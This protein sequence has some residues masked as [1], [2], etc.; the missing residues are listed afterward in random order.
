MHAVKL[1]RSWLP[2]GVLGAEA[3]VRTVKPM[4]GLV[5]KF[6]SL[7]VEEDKEPGVE[8]AKNKLNPEEVRLRAQ[9]RDQNSAY[10]GE[11]PSPGEG[12]KLCLPR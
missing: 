4:R 3:T 6:R 10:P 2:V 7:V 12:P 5:A 11:A 1:W 8:V 9:V